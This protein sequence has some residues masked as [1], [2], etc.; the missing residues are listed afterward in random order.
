MYGG[1][2][3]P[4]D[5][6]AERNAVIS[7]TDHAPKGWYVTP[8]Q[9]PA[10]NWPEK[11]LL[12]GYELDPSDMTW[13]A[14]DGGAP[15]IYRRS[16]LTAPAGDG[17]HSPAVTAEFN[18]VLAH[19]GLSIAAADPPGED[20]ETA[21]LRIDTD[22]TRQVDAWQ[23]LQTLRRAD[24]L[25]QAAAGVAGSLSLA[26]VS[27]IG[28]PAKEGHAGA[29][30][31]AVEVLAPAP[32]WRPLAQVPGR[33][34][35]VVALLD[36]GV[37][38]HGWLCAGDPATD[39]DRFSADASDLGF[40]PAGPALP[41]RGAGDTSPHDGQLDTHAGHGTFIAGLIR[42]VAPDARVLTLHAMHGD[43]VLDESTVNSA[44]RWL[45]ER[46]RRAAEDPGLF[47]DVVCLSFG[48][49]E[50]QPSDNRSTA[51][52]RQLLGELGDLGVRVVAS[53]GNHGSDAQALPAAFADPAY[54]DAGTAPATQLVSVGALNPDGSRAA[55]SNFGGW[56]RAWAVGTALMSTMPV[57]GMEQDASAVSE[58]D[59]ANL[60]D[61]F[62][63]WSGTSFAAAVFAGRLAQALV[64]DAE[65][66]GTSLC[67]VSAQAAHQRAA[68]ALAAVSRS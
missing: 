55:Y 22:G 34:R 9:P 15:T 6:A 18:A 32:P 53:A 7:D 26:R 63:R 68:R 36:T 21:W 61:G 56:V 2:L 23:A 46:V 33:R 67:D 45:L 47:V 13:G 37:D 24:T 17:V 41:A 44:L 14:T 64:D 28:M 42:Q 59:A 30:R 51:D 11:L 27:F 62:A 5:R 40:V 52:L 57:F 19:L 29:A 12:D 43:G 20:K 58:F 4:V 65:P 16:F 48:Y 10:A 1:G 39:G 25:T 54:Q 38:A 66:G 49:Y 60:V 31:E 35:P 50:R 3:P 8:A